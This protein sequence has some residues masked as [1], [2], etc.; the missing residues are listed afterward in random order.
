MLLGSIYTPN[1]NQEAFWT[2]LSTVLADKT[3]IPWLLGGDFNCVLN[4]PLDRSHPSLACALIH[5][6]VAQYKN[7]VSQW[8]LTDPWCHLHPH[9][10]IYS[11][12]S[13]THNLYVLLD[14]FR[15]TSTLLS[16]VKS[17]DYLGHLI[18]DRDAHV[19]CY[20]YR[21]TLD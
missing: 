1:S 4:I 18:S 12:Y 2:T 16:K 8:S 5:H 6:H 13:A 10:K 15:C 14:R 7:W 3:G 20:E 19:V 9:S 11:F 21:C 17:A